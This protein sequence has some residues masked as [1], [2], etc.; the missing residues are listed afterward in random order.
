[1]KA[2]DVKKK[3]TKKKGKKKKL[4][5]KDYLSTGSVLLNLACTGKPY[6]GFAK[7]KYYFI[8]GDSSSGKTFLTLTCLAEAGIN[9]N[10]KD[11]RFIY[12]NGEDGALMN[13]EKFFGKAVEKRMEAPA[14]HKGEEVYSRNIEDFYYN[15]DDAVQDGRPFIYIQDSM[16]VLSSADEGKKF[17]EQKKASRKGKKTAGSY[18]DGKAK[19]NSAGLRRLL[20]P[21]KKSGSILL[22]LCQTRDN[23]GFGAQFNPKT[24]SGGNALKFY[25]TLE[26]WASVRKKIMKQVKGKKR[27]IGMVSLLKVK[28]NRFTGKDRQVEVP[29]YHSFGFDNTGSLVEYLIDE[30]HWKGKGKDEKKIKAPEFKFEGTKE[31]LIKYIEDNDMERDLISIA[32]DVWDEIETACKINRKRR[33]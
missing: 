3:L 6:R 2:K 32:A 23:I 10:F 22:I 20:T 7:G 16:D 29:I 14:Y 1:M 8:V 30:G 17:D 25:A 12:D 18:G 15:V 21:M 24:R 19:K 13:I 27:Q 26:I 31:K 9:P 11:Y 5:G 28:K 4:T 33:Y